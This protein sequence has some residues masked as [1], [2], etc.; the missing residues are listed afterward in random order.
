MDAASI[1]NGKISKKT[2]RLL[3]CRCKFQLKQSQINIMEHKQLAKLFQVKKRL[4]N[5]RQSKME[6]GNYGKID[7]H[8]NK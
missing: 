2:I 5:L 1:L 8:D 7:K 3:T 4:R 6:K